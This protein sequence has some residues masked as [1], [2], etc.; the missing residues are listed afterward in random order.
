[1]SDDYES[2]VY[3]QKKALQS[4]RSAAAHLTRKID[5]AMEDLVWELLVFFSDMLS[6]TSTNLEEDVYKTAYELAAKALEVR[7]LTSVYGIYRDALIEAIGREVPLDDSAARRLLRFSN[8]LSDAYS[9]SYADRLKRT[10]R[11]Q[12]TE[13]MSNELRLA[14]RIQQHLL[15]KKIPQIPGYQF[16][17]RLVP[18]SEVGGDYWS[19]RYYEEDGIVTLKLADISGHGIAAATL[20]AAVKFISGGQYRAS[21]N[22]SLVI[23]KTNRVLVKETPTEILVSMVYGWLRPESRDISIVNAGHEPVFI[24][25]GDVCTNIAPTGPV[26]G[27]AET[28][29]G[30]IR[31]TLKTGDILCFA[32]DGMTEAGTGE[33]FGL[34]RLKKVVAGLKDRTA[35]EIADGAIAAV[36]DYAGRSHDDMSILIVKT[37]EPSA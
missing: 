28:I 37:V 21:S 20:V 2:L 19:I 34:E 16:A 18:A 11:H 8:L 5:P 4:W 33:P 9:Q 17:G 22:P 31:L 30:E 13:S 25:R 24:C 23:E 6:S 1:M 3:G 32:S 29:Y 36:T 14:K 26:M 7:D 10:I 12:R 15:P 35:D 27:I